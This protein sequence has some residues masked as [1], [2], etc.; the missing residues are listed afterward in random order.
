MSIRIKFPPENEI[1]T[2][3]ITFNMAVL[4][5]MIAGPLLSLEFRFVNACQSL[6]PLLTSNMTIDS[7]LSPCRIPYD[8]CR[9]SVLSNRSGLTTEC[10]MD[11]EAMIGHILPLVIY[12][13]QLYLIYK[14]VSV[15]GKYSHILTDIFWI[16]ALVVFVIIAIA[17]HG[18]SCFHFYSV[19]IIC[20]TSILLVALV[21]YLF[22]RVRDQHL[23]PTIHTYR[24]QRLTTTNHESECVITI[25]L[26]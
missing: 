6:F 7:N 20:S 24:D 19:L 5:F 17:V 1:Y 15:T 22:G 4:L 10:L 8:E 21:F 11:V 12:A 3:S 18:S 2:N 25:T 13:L 26:F 14:L 9:C 16:I 23:S